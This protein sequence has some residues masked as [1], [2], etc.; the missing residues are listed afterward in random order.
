[1][2]P[3]LDPA[4]KSGSKVSNLEFE[5]Y[6]R[7]CLSYKLISSGLASDCFSSEIVVTVGVRVRERECDCRE[8]GEVLSVFQ[9][10]WVSTLFHH[11][12]HHQHEQVQE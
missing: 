12:H 10:T 6:A 4:E 8:S 2:L 11:S 1:M 3:T 5:F 7:A 9:R